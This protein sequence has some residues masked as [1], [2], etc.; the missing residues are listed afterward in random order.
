MMMRMMK[1]KIGGGRTDEVDFAEGTKM[2]ML[3][4]YLWGGV[5]VLNKIK[6]VQQPSN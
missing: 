2:L 1:M 5:K 6:T 3:M 4:L